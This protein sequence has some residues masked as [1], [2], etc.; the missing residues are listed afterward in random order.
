MISFKGVTPIPQET[1]KPK[2]FPGVQEAPT[3]QDGPKLPP[4]PTQDT[5]QFRG[6]SVEVQPEPIDAPQPS[7]KGQANPAKQAK[8]FLNQY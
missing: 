8:I 1:P 3:A 7:F 2:P 4:Q 6:H 5:V